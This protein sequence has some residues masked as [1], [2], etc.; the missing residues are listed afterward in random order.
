[1]FCSK[2]ARVAPWIFLLMVCVGSEMCKVDLSK[3]ISL[4]IKK[5]KPNSKCQ[6]KLD[7]TEYN[8]MTVPPQSELDFKD[9]SSEDVEVTAKQILDYRDLKD[10]PKTKLELSVPP[11]PSCL[12]APLS[13]I[14][15]TLRTNQDC[16][17]AL[18]SSLRD[19]KGLTQAIPGLQCKDNDTIE[20]AEEDGSAIGDFCVQGVIQK[21]LIH[22][23]VSVTLKPRTGTKALGRDYKPVLNASFEKKKNERYI[24]DVSLS[25][26]ET[27]VHLATPGWQQGMKKLYTVSWI[28]S[29]P[30]KMQ[31]NLVF[32]VT[33]PKCRFQHTSIKVQR[34]GRAEELYSRREDEPTDSKVTVSE[35]F[36]LNMSNCI[37]EQGKFSVLTKITLQKNL[38]LVIILCVV[39]ALLVIFIIIMVV[40]CVMVRKKKEQFNHQVSEYNAGNTLRPGGDDDEAHV[41]TSIEDSLIYSHLLKRGQ[42]IGL[43]EESDAYH[44]LSLKTHSKMPRVS[45]NGGD[46]STEVP[47]PSRLSSQQ[48]RPLPDTPVSHI[49]PPEDNEVEESCPNPGP[50]QESEKGN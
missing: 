11:L 42:E 33:E 24:F 40:V 21:I 10:C 43:Y 13:S 38:R 7:R 28:V 4:Y 32:N 22:T 3:N 20:I 47:Q 36:Y 37:P 26:E 48:G 5:V 34:Q 6:M 17:I 8:N 35:N 50:R 25:K 27:S 23:N 16:S 29:V 19:V 39:A 2:S 30:S 45:N 49:L 46:G 31:A 1:M 9:C 12:P 18:T 14:S 44:Y 41:Y 15:W